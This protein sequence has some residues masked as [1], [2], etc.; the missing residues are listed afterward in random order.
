MDATAGLAE[1]KPRPRSLSQDELAQE[2]QHALFQDGESPP[3]GAT[4]CDVGFWHKRIKHQARRLS[5]TCKR[6]AP[7]SPDKQAELLAGMH[8]LRR[9]MDGMCTAYASATAEVSRQLMARQQRMSVKRARQ[10]A[11]DSNAAAATRPAADRKHAQ[12]THNAERAQAR[13]RAEFDAGSKRFAGVLVT[14]T[15]HLCDP[16]TNES[17][18]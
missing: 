17:P 6:R 15:R 8:E 4:A 5:R 14:V 11:A 13:L 7:T 3:D 9:S 10:H 18:K 16:H 2:C 1:H 12:L